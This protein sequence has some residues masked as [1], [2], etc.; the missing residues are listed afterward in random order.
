MKTLCKRV[1]KEKQVVLLVTH[2]YDRQNIWEK[3]RR[4][5]MELDP[6]RYDVFLV[7]NTEDK[8]RTIRVPK[9]IRVFSCDLDDINALGYIPIG[10]SMLPGS[11]HF[12]LLKFYRDVPKYAYYWFIEYDV[13]FSAKWS[14]LLDT[15]Y[16]SDEDFI[17]SHVE[18]F[19]EQKNFP[20]CWWH[21]SN[22]VGYP[23]DK[24]V[25]SFNPI[26][27]ISKSALSYIDKYQSQGFYAHAEVMIST[28]LY[29]AGFRIRD[30]GESG[31][32]VPDGFEN[33]FY[34][35]QEGVNKGTM[36]YR[37]LYT[38]KELS[39]NMILGK[40]FHPVKFCRLELNKN[41]VADFF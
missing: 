24:C 38:E 11:V 31:Y 41:S 37:P 1:K 6:Q 19:D 7:Y 34:I 33:R 21:V 8:S 26:F 5:K 27:R 22:H 9:R 3:Y 2:F 10:Q 18:F 20:W 15:F 40:L 29:N 30:F 16:L 39:E 17:S 13:Y 4:L 23:L 14:Q 12:P 36:R 28:C 32:F 35:K 25:K